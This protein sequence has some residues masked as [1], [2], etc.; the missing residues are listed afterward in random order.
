ML[1]CAMNTPDAICIPNGPNQSYPALSQPNHACPSTPA[2]PNGLASFVEE[3]LNMVAKAKTSDGRHAVVSF[4][5][6]NL[7]MAGGT[8][9]LRMFNDD[10]SLNQLGEQYIKSCQAWASGTPAP[11]STPAP[12][13]PP[14]PPSP[15]PNTPAPSPAPPS[16]TPSPASGDRCAVGEAVLCPGTTSSCAGD[17][18]CPDGSTCPSASTAHV[19]ACPKSK[20]KDCVTPSSAW[21]IVI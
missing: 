11:P 20:S 21:A 10:G 16:P 6:F 15:T 8:Y 9:N 17:Q 7:D 5:W 13:V 1:N 4:T 14:T 12:P 18:C 19:Q 2:L 3:L